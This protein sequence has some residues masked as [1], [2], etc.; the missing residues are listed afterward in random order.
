MLHKIMIAMLAAGLLSGCAGAGPGYTGGP[1]KKHS[2]GLKE[3]AALPA[4]EFSCDNGSSL[5]V[6]YDDQG[7]AFLKLQGV[8]IDMRA[9]PAASGA[10]YQSADGT[11]VFWNKGNDATLQTPG[12]PM[13]QCRI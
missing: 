8:E 13:V 4:H 9:A 7:N 12:G 11:V 10:K 2:S 3:R 5:T 1:Y 6:R